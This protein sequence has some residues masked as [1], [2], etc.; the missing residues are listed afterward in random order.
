MRVIGLTGSIAMGRSTAAR[1]LR[2]RGVAVHDSDAAVH[3]VLARGGGAVPDGADREPGNADAGDLPPGGH[4][5]PPSDEG[6]P[7]R[8][9]VSEARVWGENDTE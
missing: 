1:L 9:P 5:G 4:D 7:V 6:T 2:R 8:C 3:A